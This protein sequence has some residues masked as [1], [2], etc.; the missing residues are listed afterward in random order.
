MTMPNAMHRVRAAGEYLYG[1]LW[2][3]ELARA[4]GVS[5]RAVRRWVAGDANPPEDIG[6]RLRKLIDKR[7]AQLREARSALPK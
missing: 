3:S 5:D 7:I 4:L 1:P 6:P 2:Q